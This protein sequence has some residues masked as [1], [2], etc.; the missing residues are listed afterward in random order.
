MI[1][2]KL[3]ALL[4]WSSGWGPWSSW[5]IKVFLSREVQQ[6]SFFCSG[7][8]WVSSWGSCWLS[9]Q[10]NLLHIKYHCKQGSHISSRHSLFWDK[11]ADHKF[12]R[13]AIRLAENR[14]M[15]SFMGKSRVKTWCK[16]VTAAIKCFPNP[17]KCAVLKS[18]EGRRICKERAEVVRDRKECRFSWESCFI[19]TPKSSVIRCEDVV[20]WCVSEFKWENSLL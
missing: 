15:G 10:I 20:Y 2:F 8:C 16:G 12:Q 17:I 19:F 14:S 7:L 13:N 6:V 9:Q 4:S 3:Q 11:E 18:L 1:L 5:E